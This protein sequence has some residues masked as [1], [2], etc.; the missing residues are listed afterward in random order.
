MVCEEESSGVQSH[1]CAHVAPFAPSGEEPNSRS[2]ES[3]V[4]A[5]RSFHGPCA[6]RDAPCA[7]HLRP[8]RALRLSRC[9][10]QRAC[11]RSLHSDR[12]RSR[13]QTTSHRPSYVRKSASGPCFYSPAAKQ[14]FSFSLDYFYFF[15][16]KEK[17]RKLIW[18]H[19]GKQ[20][21]QQRVSRAPF[22]SDHSEGRMKEEETWRQCR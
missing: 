8:P 14:C 2:R 4:R 11:A 21:K 10:L 3:V 7:H 17:K 6:Q 16:K 22:W 13:T 9:P 18:L 19:S 15:L 20:V 5:L 12:T 1:T